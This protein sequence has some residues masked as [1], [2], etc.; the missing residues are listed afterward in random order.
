MTELFEK[1][2]VNR[3]PRWKVL[4]RLA[5]AS[6]ILHLGLLWL[7]I[8]V[9]ALRDTFNIAALIANTNIVD[10][11]YDATE[12]ADDVKLVQLS[13][14]FRYPEG[15]FTSDGRVAAEF[16]PQPTPN[17]FAAQIIAQA[18]LPKNI[19]PEVSPSP[20]PSMG[21]SPVPSASQT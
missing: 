15:Y 12:I 8:Y 20:S 3:D 13:D 19:A 11:P 7:T 6:L 17:P 10:K 5:G 9:P 14:K 21:P 1:F 16:P 2:E 4:A 18:S